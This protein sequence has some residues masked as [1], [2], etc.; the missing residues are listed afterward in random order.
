MP[1]K[2][3][4]R[5]QPDRPFPDRCDNRISDPK[6]AVAVLADELDGNRAAI[7]AAVK[8]HIFFWRT[9]PRRE[10]PRII[11]AP[12]NNQTKR[13]LPKA[14][15]DRGSRGSSQETV[16]NR[17]AREARCRWLDFALG[18]HL[19]APVRAESKVCEYASPLGACADDA[20]SAQTGQS[21]MVR[22]STWRTRPNPRVR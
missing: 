19:S 5:I 21:I 11:Y 15:R 2:D 1:S 13:W 22:E 20:S 12:L 10:V 17:L 18:R 16:N 6:F 4:G 7:A 3:S 9:V 14:Q 8:T